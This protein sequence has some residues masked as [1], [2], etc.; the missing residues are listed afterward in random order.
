VRRP[1]TTCWITLL[2]LFRPGSNF[3]QRVRT[4]G[5]ADCQVTNRGLGFAD[6]Q[7]TSEPPAKEFG[8][9]A[10]TA[11]DM[12][13]HPEQPRA[14]AI[15]KGKSKGADCKRR[16]CLSLSAKADAIKKW[17]SKGPDFKARDL[18]AWYEETYKTPLLPVTW[19]SWWRKR[20]Q[21]LHYTARFPHGDLPDR[22]MDDNH[23]EVFN[24]WLGLNTSTRALRLVLDESAHRA[25]PAEHLAGGSQEEGTVRIVTG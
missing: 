24:P 1:T 13:S 10:P 23:I 7:V 5:F 16:K 14:E 11:S 3:T 17:M 4:W 20:E 25:Q 8:S 19:H 6:C 9:A 18:L 22:I 12:E 21:I 15:K 2:L